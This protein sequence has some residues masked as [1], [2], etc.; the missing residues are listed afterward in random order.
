MRNTW[1]AYE[2]LDQARHISRLV[3]TDIGGANIEQVAA[4]LCLLA[5]HLHHAVDVTVQTWE[6]TMHVFHC[7]DLPEAKEAYA[8]IGEFADRFAE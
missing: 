7:F 6:A 5:S 4:V 2:S 3:P 8:R 1:P